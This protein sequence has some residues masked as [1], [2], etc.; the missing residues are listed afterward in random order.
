MATLKVILADLARLA[1]QSTVYTECGSD[2]DPTD[3]C[4]AN[5]KYAADCHAQYNRVMATQRVLNMIDAMEVA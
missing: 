3:C 4:P 1:G 2:Y 5:C